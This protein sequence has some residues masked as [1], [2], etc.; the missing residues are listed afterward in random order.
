MALT[1]MVEST[2]E[3]EGRWGCA[4]AGARLGRGTVYARGSD[5]ALTLPWASGLCVLGKVKQGDHRNL[6]LRSILNA[7]LM[8]VEISTSSSM[9][10]AI[11]ITKNVC[12]QFQVRKQLFLSSLCPGQGG[13]HLDCCFGRCSSQ[14][15]WTQH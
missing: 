15:H 2:W 14:C 9:I 8:P 3:V 11:A 1:G 5:D 10:P 4:A 13:R 7:A 6:I 12:A